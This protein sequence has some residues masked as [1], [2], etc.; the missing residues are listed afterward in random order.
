MSCDFKIKA[1]QD[2]VQTYH[3]A[4]QEIKRFNVQYTGDDTGRK[5]KLAILGI[6]M[7]MAN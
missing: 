3:I 5:F 2:M 7:K 4:L 1:K 6:W